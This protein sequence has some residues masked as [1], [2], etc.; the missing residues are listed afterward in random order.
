[1][2]RDLLNPEV[3]W[4]DIRD[5]DASAILDFWVR[6]LGRHHKVHR[7]ARHARPPDGAQEGPVFD[8]SAGLGLNAFHAQ[9]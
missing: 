7:L 8:H 9:G 5:E 2:R 4:S 3:V 1:V 6:R